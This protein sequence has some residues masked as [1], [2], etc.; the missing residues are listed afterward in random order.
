IL[1]ILTLLKMNLEI[2]HGELQEIKQL[3][4]L[5]AKKALTMS[6]ASLLTRLNKSHLYKLVCAKKIP[7]YKSQGGKLTYFEKAELEAWQ[8]M[9][10]VSTTDEI[11]AKAQTYCIGNK[12][13]GK[14]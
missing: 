3:T 12:K 6:D 11:E 14:K 9:H 2:I 4:L 13:G 7:Y 5:S 1:L 10:R 8:L